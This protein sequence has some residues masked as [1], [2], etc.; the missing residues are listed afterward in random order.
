M[1]RKLHPRRVC[2]AFLAAVLSAACLFT[3]PVS[4]YAVTEDL[5]GDGVINVYD[6]ILSK[7]ESVDASSPVSMRV[8][9]AEGLAGSIVTVKVEITENPGCNSMGIT[10]DYSGG[11]EL[12]DTERPI[13]IMQNDFPYLAF[14][15]MPAHEKK[16][17]HLS[18]YGL[19]E[20]AKG[21]LME[22]DFR[23]PDGVLPGTILTVDIEKAEVCNDKGKLP[24]LTERG[25]VTVLPPPVSD[26][27]YRTV[28]GCDISQWQGDI[29][30]KAFAQ[31]EDINFAILRAGYGRNAYQT[32]TKFYQNYYAAKAA[33]VPL[34]AYWYSYAMTPEDARREAHAC[35]EVIKGMT[36]EY[37]IAFDFEEKKQLALPVEKASAIVDAF[38]SE[39]E[40]MGYYVVLYCSSFFL[41]H[42]ISQQVKEHYDVWVAHYN[43]PK[44]TY[45]GSYG[46][47][48]YGI[49]NGKLGLNG[50]LDMDY[51]YRNYP[52]IMART[53]LNGNA[54][55]NS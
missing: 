3:A 25:K 16:R 51:C 13:R 55:P 10:L 43:V 48:Q 49:E 40:S 6:Y 11:L 47:W 33:G 21:V 22:M 26:R 5:N 45:L 39:M 36:F 9:A 30:W 50:D 17:L 52:S 38:C 53:G 35:A 19:M 54:K 41:N 31:N 20:D 18:S 37:P 12:A 4:A 32:D 29:D 15:Y 14:S 1:L 27:R 23:I 7:R 42:T 8:T 2:A 24:I 28:K 34:G 46:M 44:P